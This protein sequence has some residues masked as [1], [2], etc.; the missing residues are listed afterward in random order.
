MTK[1]QI[2]GVMPFDTVASEGSEETL[3]AIED[4]QRAVDM[5]DCT[6]KIPMTLYLSGY[7]YQE[8]AEKMG[9][10]LGTVKSRIHVSRLRL[11]KELK[12]FRK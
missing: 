8:I 2:E 6:Y 5:L 4:I 7:K 11:Q 12:D 10:P 3:F 1:D 9:I